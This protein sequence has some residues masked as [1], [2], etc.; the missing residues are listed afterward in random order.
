V[1]GDYCAKHG[2]EPDPAV[3]A[4]DTSYETQR[5]DLKVLSASG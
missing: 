3:M 2:L 5:A 4:F 1:Y